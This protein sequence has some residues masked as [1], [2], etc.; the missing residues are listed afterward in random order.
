MPGVP[1][2]CAPQ[3]IIFTVAADGVPVGVTDWIA[4]D[5]LFVGIEP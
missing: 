4:T 3:Q 5:E 1:A 2:L